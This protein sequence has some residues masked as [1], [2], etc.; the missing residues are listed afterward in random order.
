MEIQ[1]SFSV[2]EKLLSL[3]A[4]KVG[5]EHKAT[6]GTCIRLIQPFE[7]NHSHVRHTRGVDGRQRHCVVI[8]N[9]VG[10]GLKKPAIKQ[11]KRVVLSQKPTVRSRRVGCELVSIRHSNL[12]GA[13]SRPQVPRWRAAKQ[14]DAF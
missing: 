9:F 3:G 1:S 12:P 4:L 5:V 14:R 7:K 8:V 6:S 13:T 10:F 2:A 11:G